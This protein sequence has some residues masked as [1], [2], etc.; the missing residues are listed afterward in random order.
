MLSIS[1][2]ETAFAPSMRVETSGEEY[3]TVSI[4]TNGKRAETRVYDDYEY[5]R[6]AWI[7]FGADAQSV[8]KLFHTILRSWDNL[9]RPAHR[10]G[11]EEYCH[12]PNRS[13]DDEP[14]QHTMEHLNQRVFHG[15]V[16]KSKERCGSNSGI[17]TMND[18]QRMAKIRS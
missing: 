14:G 9:R 8:G 12:L 18:R 4:L 11:G 3:L 10:R 2:V 13:T 7:A 17:Q 15:L 1:G 6:Q 5:G 16:G